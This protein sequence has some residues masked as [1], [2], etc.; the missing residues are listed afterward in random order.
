MPRRRISAMDEG[1]PLADSNAS[2][3]VH[4]RRLLDA[5]PQTFDV[6][7]AVAELRDALMPLVPGA[8]RITIAVDT[9]CDFRNPESYRPTAELVRNLAEEGLAGVSVQT[10]GDAGGFTGAVLASLGSSGYPLELYHSPHTVELFYLDSM[11]IGCVFVWRE[12]NKPSLTAAAVDAIESLRPFLESA[13]TS[14]IVRHQH[15]RPQERIV[16]QALVDA[17]NRYG[18]TRQERR[19]LTYRMLGHSYKAIAEEIGISADSVRKHLLSVH[20]KTGTSSL[21][22][23][24]GRLFMP[25]V[26]AGHDGLIRDT[27]ET[28]PFGE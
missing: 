16:D 1:D 5:L 8:D 19:I 21:A 6:S 14:I 24:F 2:M 7:E 28:S 9:A 15:L 20:R 4:L 12:R 25:D 18:L 11:Q 17:V 26:G 27:D 22:E 10:A 13:V 23:V 3:A